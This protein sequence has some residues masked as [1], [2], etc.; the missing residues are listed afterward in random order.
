MSQFSSTND[1]A[2]DRRL[3]YWNSILESEFPGMSVSAARDID[4]CCR[5]RTIGDLRVARLSSQKARVHRWR[6]AAPD[7]EYGRTIAHIQSEGTSLAFRQDAAGLINTGDLAIGKADMPYAMHLSDR[8]VVIIV[9]FPSDFLSVAV[10]DE[11]RRAARSEAIKRLHDFALSVIDDELNE[12]H[13]EDNL[14]EC[15]LDVFSTLLQTCLNTESSPQGGDVL[16][17]H[18]IFEFIESSIQDSALRTNTIARRLSF[19]CKQVQRIFATLGMT[20]SQFILNRRVN[21][22]AFMLRSSSFDGTVTDLA[23]DVGFSDAAH[24]CRSFRRIF[25]ATPT[26]YAKSQR[27]G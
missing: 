15:I 2:S 19:S 11:G 6:S 10:P 13:D 14:E 27:H 9:D 1:I 21:L 4:A 26:E 8:N 23:M 16:D 18:R 3:D 25:G 17:C 22:A 5:L 7:P 12:L 20:P 24:F